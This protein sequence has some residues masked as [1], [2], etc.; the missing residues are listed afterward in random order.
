VKQTLHLVR[1]G[2]LPPGVAAPTDWVVDLDT[3][4]L[5]DR[6]TPPLPPGPVSHESVLALI[7][8]ADLVITW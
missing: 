2:A 5:H 4:D 8:R 3:L 7:V 6:G 1:R